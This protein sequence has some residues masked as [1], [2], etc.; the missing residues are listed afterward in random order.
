MAQK[1]ATVADAA[2]SASYPWINTEFGKSTNQDQWQSW[3]ATELKGLQINNAVGWVYWCYCSNP[4]AEPSWNLNSQ[5]VAEVLTFLTPYMNDTMPT[6]TIS[7]TPPT[8]ANATFS[9]S[10]KE[11][12]LPTPSVP[13]IASIAAT[14]VIVS[15]LFV[16]I[17][18][19]KNRYGLKRKERILF[20]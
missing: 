3:F 2:H 14:L 8:I 5:V 9:N 16:S 10:S 18:W 12:S 15:I 6:P 13:E 11:P 4:K 7:Q 17:I 1:I 20:N 19:L